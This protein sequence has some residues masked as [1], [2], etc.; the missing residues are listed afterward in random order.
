MQRRKFT[1]LR[2]E[3]NHC[4]HL[5]PASSKRLIA[6][7]FGLWNSFPR[8]RT[9]VRQM[10]RSTMYGSAGLQADRYR[11]QTGRSVY[12]QTCKCSQN[13]RSKDKPMPVD[14]ARHSESLTHR[15]QARSPLSCTETQ[16]TQNSA[17]RG[18]P[19]PAQRSV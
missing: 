15:L 10:L 2:R 4:F 8:L 13:A 14:L 6:Y 7:F 17:L 18:P 3:Y 5:W 19:L 16:A 11:H 12:S 1:R 9:L